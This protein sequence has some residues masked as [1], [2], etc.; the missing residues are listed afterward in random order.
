VAGIVE[1]YVSFLTLLS[2]IV[3]PI[4]GVYTADYLLRKNTY[5]SKE[6]DLVDPVR[7]SSIIALLAGIALGFVT[8]PR[9]ALGLG[10]VSLTRLPAIDA[11]AGGFVCRG[12]LEA[13]SV[14]VSRYRAGGKPEQGAEPA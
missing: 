1:R 7:P 5:E 14:A 3:P 8:S 6:P 2:I 11:F 4:S 13:I 12:L 10:V 9:G